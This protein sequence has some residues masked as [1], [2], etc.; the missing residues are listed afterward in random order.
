M[1]KLLEDIKKIKEKYENKRKVD[2]FNVFL[3]LNKIDEEVRLHSRFISYLLSP[4]S[5]H[6]KGNFFTER[7]V[8]MLGLSEDAFDCT[9]TYEVRPNEQ[10][11]SEYKDIDILLINKEKKQAI[12]IENKI[13][14]KD[15]NDENA[16]DGYKGQLERYYN[17]IERGEDKNGNNIGSFRCSEVS[18]VFLSKNQL[19]VPTDESKG[20][21]KKEVKCIHYE[22]DIVNWL[23]ECIKDLKCL[24]QN[25]SED[26]VIYIIEQYLKTVKRM[27]GKDFDISE[28][29]E[30]RDKVK[31]KEELRYLFGNFK[32]LKWHTVHEF[33]VEIKNRLEE[34]K[35][36]E[37]EFFPKEDI[38]DNVTQFTH[39]NNGNVNLGIKFTS[40]KDKK[41][42]IVSDNKGLTWG[43]VS[44]EDEL[45]KWKYF[46]D[47]CLQDLELF[48]F[49]QKTVYDLID[50]EKRSVVIDKI[51]KEINEEQNNN[52]ENLRP[53]W[54]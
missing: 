44:I 23:N 10:N 22:N 37:V 18:V 25:L 54:N 11:K 45:E 51:I 15:S 28:I 27:V 49:S 4:T 30:L 43:L 33:W 6:S 36:K 52:F 1:E 26:Y 32:H 24:N 50:K 46:D 53:N 12:I 29:D 40:N 3:A 16:K 17:T 20:N 5:N 2:G 47:D 38:G 42:Y 19:R 34:K 9:S 14:A 39:H 13:N 41:I 31:N 35:Y 8:K 21:L 48:D 7:F